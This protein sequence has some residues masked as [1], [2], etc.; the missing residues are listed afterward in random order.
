M[1]ELLI[2]WRTW[3]FNGLGALFVLV[4][5]LLGAPE[6]QAIIPPK[7]LPYVVAAVFLANLWMRPRPAAIGSD[8]E[9]Q[10]A[11]EIKDA[12]GNP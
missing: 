11:K 8:P 10:F 12:N 5:P 7:Y 1:T 4:G 2:R 9:V 3:L 6:I